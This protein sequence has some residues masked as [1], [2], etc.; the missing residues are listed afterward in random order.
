MSSS[1]MAEKFWN[2]TVI[3]EASTHGELCYCIIAAMHAGSDRVCQTLI[4]NIW[5]QRAARAPQ[6]SES[7]SN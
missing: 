7:F 3:L 1:T 6:T 4:T 5:P 2:F